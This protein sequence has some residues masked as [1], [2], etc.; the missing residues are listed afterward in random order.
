MSILITTYYGTHNHPL[1]VGSITAMAST[2]SA[3]FFRL[4]DSSNPLS[5]GTY[6]FTKACLLYDMIDPNDPSQG[7]VVDFTSQFPMPKSPVRDQDQ[8]QP[9]KILVG[10]DSKKEG[11]V[12]AAPTHQIDMHMSWCYSLI[13]TC[14]HLI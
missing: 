3:D 13:S 6:S 12:F 1:P 14:C 10:E 7:I 9:P 4:L 8:N 2:A 5:E 11:T